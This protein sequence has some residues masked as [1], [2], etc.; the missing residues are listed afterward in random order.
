[1]KHF[2]K[3]L[4]FLIIGRDTL[5]NMA[6]TSHMCLL[7]L[8]FSSSVTSCTSSCT[9]GWRLPTVQRVLL[10]SVERGRGD[11]KHLHICVVKAG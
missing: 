5:P 7:E 1:M 10:T 2:L 8:M 4:K 11:N 6:A 9:S 3:K